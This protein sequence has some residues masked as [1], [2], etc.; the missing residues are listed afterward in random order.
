MPLF[1][2]VVAREILDTSNM[3]IFVSTCQRFTHNSR[4]V[5]ITLG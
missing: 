3:G 1:D 5:H 2:P 4:G